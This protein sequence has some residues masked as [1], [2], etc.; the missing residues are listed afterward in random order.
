[1]DSVSR[2]VTGAYLLADKARTPLKVTKR[3]NGLDVEL[4][5]KVPDPIAG[6]LVLTTA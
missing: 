1:M 2:N 5:G 3:G 6:V 4:P